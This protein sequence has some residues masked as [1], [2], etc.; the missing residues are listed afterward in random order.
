MKVACF[1]G[2]WLLILVTVTLAAAALWMTIKRAEGYDVIFRSYAELYALSDVPR[3]R[4]FDRIADDTIEV[5]LTGGAAGQIVP[6]PVGAGDARQRLRLRPGKH[7]YQVGTTASGDPLEVT[8]AWGPNV[9]V[10]MIGDSGLAIGEP[11]PYSPADF[12]PSPGMYLRDELEHAQQRMRQADI[13]PHEPVVARAQKLAVYLHDLLLPHRGVPKP[14]MRQLSGYRQLEEA[15]AG[16]SG[17]YCANHSEIFTFFA[18]AVGVPA[19]MVDVAGQLDGIALGAHSFVEVYAPGQ[20]GWMYLDLQMG[21]AG[22]SDAAGRFLNGAAL[23]QR[24][25]QN[26]TSDL[27]VHRIRDGEL[28]QQPYASAQAHLQTFLNPESTLVYLWATQERFSPLQRLKRLLVKPRP[29]YTLKSS[30]EG[31]R[32][33]ITMTY[34]ALLGMTGW[35]VLRGLHLTGRCGCRP[36]SRLSEPG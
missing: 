14:H 11:S 30:R 4:G 34:L 2:E 32:V 13:G 9:P 36:R 29:G 31:A 25:A 8:I 28:R 12:V 16:R 17:V 6:A 20:E 24:M 22:V 35:M 23:L 26:S 21:I 19:R 3:I 1:R 7:R 18:T 5:H 10:P 27:T 33:R 15:L